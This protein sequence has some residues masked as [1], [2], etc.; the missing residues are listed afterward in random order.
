[1]DIKIC[2]RNIRK[3][4]R[5]F[6]NAPWQFKKGTTSGTDRLGNYEVG[7]ESQGSRLKQW[8]L[9]VKSF[10]ASTKLKRSIMK[11]C[12]TERWMGLL[13]PKQP[14]SLPPPERKRSL[15]PITIKSAN[16]RHPDAAALKRD[17]YPK[18]KKAPTMNSN[19]GR[20]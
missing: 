4:S 6:G 14:Q 8:V 3:S 13:A 7:R 15:D 17:L 11:T 19:Q 20:A 5:A 10:M 12:R 2:R 16:D 1:M 9:R 18:I